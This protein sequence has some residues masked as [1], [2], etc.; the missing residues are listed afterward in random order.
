[1]DPKSTHIHIKECDSPNGTIRKMVLNGQFINTSPKFDERY[2]SESMDS[3]PKTT[4]MRFVVC[5][6]GI[7]SLAMSQMSRSV[8]NYCITS[9]VDPRMIQ[10]NETVSS[11]GSC[12][13]SGYDQSKNVYFTQK[14]IFDANQ[15]HYNTRIERSTDSEAYHELI[16]K[17]QDMKTYEDKFMWT[18]EEQSFVLGGFFY[19]YFLFMIVGGRISEIYG[20]KYVLL[21]AVAG[22]GIINLATPWMAR[23]SLSL[24]FIS[25]VI[26]GALQSSVYPTMYALINRWLTMS[27]A[28][29]YAPMIKMSLRLGQVLASLVPGLILKWPNVFYVV[30]TLGI[31]W[32]ILWLFIATS[33][34]SSNSWVSKSELAHILKK[35]K[36]KIFEDDNSTLEKANEI[37]VENKT[38]SKTPWLK[39]ITSPSVIGLIIAKLAYNFCNDF[40]TVELPSYLKYVHHTSMQRISAI[41]TAMFTIQVSLVLLAGWLAKVM[42]QKRPF[43]LS[44]TSTRKIFESAATFGSGSLLLLMIFNDWNLTY[45]T[46]D[47]QLISL[48]SIFVVGGEMMLPYDLSEEYPAT[49]M[50]IANSIAN[51]S[52]MIVTTMTG[53]ILG[54]QGG[55]QARWNII[56]ALIACLDALGGLLFCLLVKAEPIDF[57]SK[58]KS[59]SIKDDENTSKTQKSEMVVRVDDQVFEHPN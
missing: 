45:V 16:S 27:E 58:R 49:I 15:T 50:A 3:P 20:A 21:L 2:N 33:D 4:K 59:N 41:T 43:G 37:S 39:I 52:G 24:L 32:S 11:G 40:I 23:H 5:T 30:G 56:I 47:L 57:D 48:M 38:K 46:I 55:S 19:S 1:M 42:V 51:M 7:I 29:I 18:I 12:P 36:R 44:K 13:L 28:S 25:R 10:S 8:I 31:V 26:M 53:I 9:M 17:S 6:L 54:D 22:S 34:P 14:K 35:K